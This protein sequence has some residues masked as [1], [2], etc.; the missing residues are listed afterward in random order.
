ML[1]HD[2]ARKSP[3][4][5]RLT[6]KNIKVDLLQTDVLAYDVQQPTWDNL[7]LSAPTGRDTV[8]N[9]LDVHLQLN[10]SCV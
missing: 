8:D 9:I 5:S 10:P 1:N 2:P 6:L 3:I 7:L 4:R